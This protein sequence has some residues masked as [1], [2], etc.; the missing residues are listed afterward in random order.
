MPIDG[1]GRARVMP[2]LASAALSAVSGFCHPRSADSSSIGGVNEV[3]GR[4]HVGAGSQPGRSELGAS[5][6][7]GVDD[8]E[9][10]DAG[11]LGLGDV[12]VL[13]VDAV[14]DVVHSRGLVVGR[15]T[16]RRR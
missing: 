3:A 10:Y 2:R 5:V 1:G 7:L 15:E 11:R 9:R 6:G 12:L 14:G 16:R 8:L 4:F 13:I